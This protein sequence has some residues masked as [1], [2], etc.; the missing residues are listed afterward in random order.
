[1][2]LVIV[3]LLLLVLPA[4]SVIIDVLGKGGAAD[5]I[6][7]VG[8]WFVFWPVGVR[9]FIAG[10]RQVVQP[11]FTAEEIFASQD[12][13]VRRFIDGVSEEKEL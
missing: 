1:M 2:Y 9:L 5:V 7:L 8:K 13:V 12:P 4:A 10:L 11:Q 3:I 6:L